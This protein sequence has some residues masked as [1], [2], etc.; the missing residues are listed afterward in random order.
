MDT[1]KNKEGAW[2]VSALL[3]DRDYNGAYYHSHSYYG[4]TKREA[5]KHYIA[6]FG[7]RFDPSENI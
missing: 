3:N 6:E 7:K 5:I 1:Y 2:V 4:F